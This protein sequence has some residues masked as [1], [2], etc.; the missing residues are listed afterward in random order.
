M[1]FLSFLIFVFIVLGI[2][3][4]G[5]WAASYFFPGHPAIVDKLIWGIAVVMIVLKLLAVTGLL[6]HDPQMPHV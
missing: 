3:W 5:V 1:G 4:L 6:S 2:A